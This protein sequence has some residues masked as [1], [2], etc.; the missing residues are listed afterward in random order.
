MLDQSETE[1]GRGTDLDHSESEPFYVVPEKLN[2]F[3]WG[4]VGFLYLVLLS[5]VVFIIYISCTWNKI[6]INEYT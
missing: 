2:Y 3:Q 1:P 6:R 5:L 4:C